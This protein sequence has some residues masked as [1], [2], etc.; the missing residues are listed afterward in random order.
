MSTRNMAVELDENDN[1]KIVGKPGVTVVNHLVASKSSMKDDQL[2]S[3][4][5]GHQNSRITIWR[6]ELIAKNNVQE[7]IKKQVFF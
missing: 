7:K 5:D 1:F 4:F 6:E 3:Q 2:K